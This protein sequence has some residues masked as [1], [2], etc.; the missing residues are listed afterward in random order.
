MKRNS[1]LIGILSLIAMALFQ[2]CSQGNFESSSLDTPTTITTKTVISDDRIQNWLDQD[3]VIVCPAVRCMAPPEGCSYEPENTAAAEVVSNRCPTG[4]GKIVCKKKLP[5][6]RQPI[7]PIVCPMIACSEVPA[8]CQRVAAATTVKN[9]KG[10]DL[11]C[12]EIVCE[13]KTTLSDND[14]AI[15]VQQSSGGIR[16][17]IR[18]CPLIMCAEAP[19]GCFYRQNSAIT[20]KN[21]CPTCGELICKKF[22]IEQLPLIDVE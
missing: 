13:D 6:V 10:C 22:P 15:D 12:G 4:C 7:E 20:D 9:T 1:L 2:N 18:I 3:R 11:N 8:G 21:A 17:N 5:I 19:S 16:R 14:G